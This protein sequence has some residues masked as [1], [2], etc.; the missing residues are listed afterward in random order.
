MIDSENEMLTITKAE[1][2]RLQSKEA[3]FHAIFEESPFILVINDSEDEKYV[4]GN[5]F[6]KELNGFKKKEEFI[7]KTAVEIGLSIDTEHHRKMLEIFQRDGEINSFEGDYSDKD[8]LIHNFLVWTKVIEIQ[9]KKYAFTTLQ[10]VT[11]NNKFKNE[12]IESESKYKGLYQQML[13]TLDELKESQAR[14]RAL[15]SHIQEVREEEKI[16]ISREIHDELGH[17]LTAV[18]LDLEQIILDQDESKVFTE[19]LEPV[20][21]MV[22][23]CIDTTRKISYDLHPAI[24]DH[25]GLIPALEWM[26]SQF[27]IRTRLKCEIN[28][29][30]DSPQFNTSESIVVFRI[31][32][33]IFTNI[34]RHAKA[35]KIWVNLEQNTDKLIFTI[36]DDGIGFNTILLKKSPALGMLSM[37]ERA[38]SIGAE[39]L[40]DSTPGK[41]TSIKLVL[42]PSSKAS[43]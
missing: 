32:Q 25:F 42:N 16:S 22:D 11:E 35:G 38:F 29:P 41:G 9:H 17:L 39:L 14:L 24:L 30:K 13:N 19:K 15:A 21:S 2:E 27:I 37:K 18:K 3:F 8:G 31:F 7:G 36:A 33:E 12:L 40:I 26:I 28:L 20:I 10:D 23:S 6:F 5:H 43:E 1:F 34:A 4:A